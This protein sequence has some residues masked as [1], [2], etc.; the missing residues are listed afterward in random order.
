[1]KVLLCAKVACENKSEVIMKKKKLFLSGVCAVLLAAPFMPNPASA[2]MGDNSGDSAAL[3]RQTIENSGRPGAMVESII[4]PAYIRNVIPEVAGLP[5]KYD[6]DFV[7]PRS[8]NFIREVQNADK[9]LNQYFI[10][11]NGNVALFRMR[12]EIENL[13]SYLV[14]DPL[15][16]V[17]PASTEVPWDFASNIE[18]IAPTQPPITVTTPFKYNGPTPD[19]VPHNPSSRCQPLCAYEVP[20]PAPTPIPGQGIDGL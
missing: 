1:V 5:G 15:L 7:D 6:V 12:G 9:D 2:E 8:F 16:F 18:Y 20:A 14:N 19:P 3:I 11:P 4:S 10:L 13:P 17:L